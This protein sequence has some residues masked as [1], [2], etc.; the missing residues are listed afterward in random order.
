MMFASVT[1]RNWRSTSSSVALS[2][3][4]STSVMLPSFAAA[5]T[6][7]AFSRASAESSTSS[8]SMTSV[9]SRAV[10]A[11]SVRDS[12]FWSTGAAGAAGAAWAAASS[13]KAQRAANTAVAMAVAFI[14]SSLL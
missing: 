8:R 14:S 3:E 10:A 6:N 5:L 9:V 12:A 7:V 13:P 4:M 1:R 2:Q 11:L